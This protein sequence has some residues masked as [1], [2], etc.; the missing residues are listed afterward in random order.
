VSRLVK[1]L[2]V[3][4]VF[5]VFTAADP[6]SSPPAAH[7]LIELLTSDGLLVLQVPEPMARELGESL[8]R[9]SPRPDHASGQTRTRPADL[10]R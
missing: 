1:P 8:S 7:I 5:G 4:D 6:A 9:V 2:A 3:Q 10:R